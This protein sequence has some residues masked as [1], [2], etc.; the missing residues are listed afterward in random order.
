MSE[1]QTIKPKLLLN[2]KPYFDIQQLA[3]LIQRT[4]RTV[5][6]IVARNGIEYLRHGRQP[7]FSPDAVEKYMEKLTVKAK[8]FI[9]KE[10][11]K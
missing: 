7:Y 2:N 3:A 5:Q 11:K 6:R 1:C 9:N 10:V 4:P 8:I